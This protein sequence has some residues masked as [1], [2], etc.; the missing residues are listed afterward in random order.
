MI[1]LSAKGNKAVILY[2]TVA[3]KL[4]LKPAWRVSGVQCPGGQ[5]A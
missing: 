4:L 2:L 5:R 1:Y 3:I